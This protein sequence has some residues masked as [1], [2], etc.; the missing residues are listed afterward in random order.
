MPKT[1]AQETR[2]PALPSGPLPAE[3]GPANFYQPAS[4][5]REQSLGWLL[6]KLQQSIVHQAGRQLSDCD[7]THAQ[8]GVL[9]VLRFGSNQCTTTALCRELDA[10]AGALSRLLDR[11]E[12]KGLV[13]RERSV[14]DR[15]VVQV[16][17]TDAGFA[18]SDQLPALLSDVFNAHLKGFSHEE[19]QL[20]LSLL[21]R[22]IDNG[23][24]LR[25]AQS[26]QGAD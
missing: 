21:R 19:W 15:R 6:R 14:E 11:L 3:E 13:Q 9:M 23:E 12:A 20:L 18:A 10:D 5:T 2:P 24:A 1:K 22:M 17:L 26:A 4:Y 25:Q 16:R 7:L 8:W